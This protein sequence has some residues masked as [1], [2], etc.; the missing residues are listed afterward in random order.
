MDEQIREMEELIEQQNDLKKQTDDLAKR[1]AKKTDPKEFKDLAGK[2]SELQKKTADLANKVGKPSDGSEPNE[3]P[4]ANQSPS[5][6]PQDGNGKG[7]SPSGESKSGTGQCKACLGKASQ[8][9]K[10][11]AQ[12][13]DKQLPK[14]AQQDEQK[15]VEDLKKAVEALKE[16]RKR[17]A[18]LPKEMLDQ[19][20]AKQDTTND[21]AKKLLDEMKESPES[22]S[23]SG[24]KG[25]KN[26]EDA[27]KSM[28]GASE[29]LRGEDIE[30][31]AE[32]QEKA[33]EELKKAL[34]EIEQRLAQLREDTLID[35]LARLEARFREMLDRQK[36]VT[37]ATAA[38]HA[39]R[40]ERGNLARADRLKLRKLVAEEKA[41][42]EEAFQTIDILV[43]DGTSVVFPRVVT[44]LQAD[45][46][47]IAELLDDQQ[48]GA[49]TQSIQQETEVTLQ[50]L[51]D[52]LRRNLKKKK[53]GGG[54]GSCDCEP[55]LLPGSAE[56][57]LLR[58][59]QLRV[60][61]RTTAFDKLELDA[62]LKAMRAKE[63]KTLT[64]LQEEVAEMTLELAEKY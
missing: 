34:D 59:M 24:P 62:E 63:A 25:Q 47:R 20:A 7:G 31:A 29:S 48:T 32:E 13:L 60:N 35:R 28:K 10:S 44:N 58:S 16:E 52:A 41:L 42:A 12:K 30:A 36:E 14:D 49:F 6:K 39:R 17:I 22:E 57:K 61:R 18:R 33:V 50:E 11:A 27:Q 64:D 8:S 19:M 45:F 26:V 9:Q 21:D 4:A 55:P 46:A 2:Q 3:N 1:D 37:I 54:G 53:G 56:L 38:L 5:E 51:I 40:E 43:E 15:A 23:K